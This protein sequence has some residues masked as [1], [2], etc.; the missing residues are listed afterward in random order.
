MI[1]SEMFVAGHIWVQGFAGLIKLKGFSCNMLTVK[2]PYSLS[3]RLRLVK[4]ATATKPVNC[5]NVPESPVISF[6][7]EVIQFKKFIEM[8]ALF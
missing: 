1:E 5:Y 2:K 7:L 3:E 6:D 4:H 8:I